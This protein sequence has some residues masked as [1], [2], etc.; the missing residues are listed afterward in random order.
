MT[1]KDVL[2][3]FCHRFARV[4][5]ELS[6]GFKIAELKDQVYRYRDRI[7]TVDQIAL[8]WAQSEV[9]AAVLFG[10]AWKAVKLID[11]LGSQD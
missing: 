4:H 9:K 7:D 11:F 1:A 2:Q 10:K 3:I 6:F 5:E 8:S